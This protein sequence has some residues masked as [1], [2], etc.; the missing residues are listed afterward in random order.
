M[1]IASPNRLEN[2]KIG[3]VRDRGR[4]GRRR[5]KPRAG[6]EKREHAKPLDAGET[7]RAVAEPFD[8]GNSRRVEH[9][10]EEVVQSGIGLVDE[11]TTALDPSAR[12]TRHRDREIVMRV[13][14]RLAE[15][16]AEED[17]RMVEQ[18]AVSILRLRHASQQIRVE[19]D[20][21]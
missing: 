12:G 8:L 18:R 2:A 19:A 16:A 17:E 3:R 9:V 10:Q 1:L 15:A 13:E 6:G 20:L 4:D 14:V 11:M 21:Q 7:A 5:E